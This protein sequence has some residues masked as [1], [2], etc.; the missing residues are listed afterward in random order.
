M[1]RRRRRDGA[2]TLSAWQPLERRQRVIQPG[3]AAHTAASPAA[4]AA[5]QDGSELWAND[6]Y[7]VIVRRYPDGAAMHLSIRR[8]DRGAARDWRD[9]QQ[10]KNEIAGPDVEAVELYPA[11]SRLVDAANQYHLW[12]MAP[13]VRL[14][15]GYRERYV[16]DASDL[17]DTGARQR[18]LGG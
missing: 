12:C 10:I 7:V 16:L 17:P 9:F 11:E 3:L 15:F 4:L 8:Q 6:R 18:E 1:G 14:P 2:G 13:G 5:I